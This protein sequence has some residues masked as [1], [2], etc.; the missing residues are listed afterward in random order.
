MRH[1]KQFLQQGS[2]GGL[3]EELPVSGGGFVYLLIYTQ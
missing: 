1:L 3:S 2:E